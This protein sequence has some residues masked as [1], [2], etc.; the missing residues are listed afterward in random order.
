MVTGNNI[1]VFQTTIQCMCNNPTDYMHLGHPTEVRVQK[2]R[3]SPWARTNIG[4]MVTDAVGTHEIATII[5]LSPDGAHLRA[6]R[7]L[8]DPGRTLRLAFPASMEELATTLEIEAKIKHAYAP[9]VAPG[10]AAS[11]LEY[12]VAFSNV[13]PSDALWL[14]ALV[15][16]HIAEG[17]M[18]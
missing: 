16:R 15:Y 6:P 1:Y 11:M 18:A 2:L 9:K 4:V 5:N 8:G 13:S 14:K 17:Y 7:S 10:S 3:K 12:G